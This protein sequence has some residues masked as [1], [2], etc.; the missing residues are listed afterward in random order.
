MKQSDPV[1]FCTP[2]NTSFLIMFWFPTRTNEKLTSNHLKYSIL[3][4]SLQFDN[5]LV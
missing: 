1:V 5:D 2:E 4:F 3:D